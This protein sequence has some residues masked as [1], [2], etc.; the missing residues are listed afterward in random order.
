MTTTACDAGYHHAN[1]AYQTPADV[2]SLVSTAQDFAAT[3]A[4]DSSAF[5]HLTTTNEDL[6]T[7]LAHMAIQNQQLQQQVTDI[8]QHVMFLATAAPPPQ[9]QRQLQPGCGG[10]GRQRHNTRGH[11]W[12]PS[13]PGH[14]PYNPAPYNPANAPP[15]YA[16][17]AAH[18]QPAPPP[19]P[20]PCINRPCLPPVS[21][22]ATTH[23]RACQHGEPTRRPM[24]TKT[25]ANTHQHGPSAHQIANA[26]TT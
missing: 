5:E 13:P 12:A 25:Q 21:R 7:Q 19:T 10:H 17:L 23:I 6:N 16:F 15:P 26:T 4:A 18:Y 20:P 24:P 11:Y 8:Q 2:E 14:P 1:A 9:H 22:P 3:L